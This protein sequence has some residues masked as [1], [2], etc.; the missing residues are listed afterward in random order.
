M[1]TI[2]FYEYAIIQK[3]CQVVQYRAIGKKMSEDLYSVQFFHGKKCM[4]NNRFVRLDEFEIIHSFRIL[5]FNDN[6]EYYKQ[7]LLNAYK[8]MI[9][10]EQAK[11]EKQ[12]NFLKRLQ[13]NTN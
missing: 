11:I 7:L 9:E 5:S 6:Y 4:S 8:E 12:K 10:K 13:S 2:E 3:H 1:E